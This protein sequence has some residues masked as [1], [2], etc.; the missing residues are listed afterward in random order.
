MHF[1]NKEKKLRTLKNGIWRR[2]AKKF[3]FITCYTRVKNIDKK[4]YAANNNNSKHN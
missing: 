4:I 3:T 2:V 1:L